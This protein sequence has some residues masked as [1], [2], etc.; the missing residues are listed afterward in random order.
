MA[1]ALARA[2]ELRPHC[3]VVQR[4]VAAAGGGVGE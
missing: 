4:E 1:G 2:L 3:P